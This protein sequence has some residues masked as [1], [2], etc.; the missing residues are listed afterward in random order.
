MSKDFFSEKEFQ[1]RWK[2]VRDSMKKFEIELLMVIAPTN[3]NYLIGTPAKG[4]RTRKKNKSSN[5]KQC[6]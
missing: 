2:K 6:C 5:R 1:L 3:I 4:Y